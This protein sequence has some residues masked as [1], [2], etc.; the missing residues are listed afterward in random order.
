[1]EL[2]IIVTGSNLN[3]VLLYRRNSKEAILAELHGGRFA[4]HLAERSLFNTLVKR[5]WWDGMRRDVR[6]HCLSCLTCATRK[7]P[8]RTTRPPLQPIPIGNPFHLVGIDI[9]QLSLTESGNKY[10]VVAMDYLPK[11]PEVFPVPDQTA[12]TVAKD[13][14]V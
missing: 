4:G 8:G 7:G 3:H 10:A 12:T 6:R 14:F 11:W 13:T 1:M 2:S 5:Y 9:L